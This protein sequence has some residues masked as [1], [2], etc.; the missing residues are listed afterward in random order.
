[1]NFER[2]AELHGL[3]INHLT[4]DR[5]VRVPTI[6]K[7]NSRNGAYIFDGQTGS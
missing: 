1:M 4:Y 7:P 5:W 6:D 2:F 3:I